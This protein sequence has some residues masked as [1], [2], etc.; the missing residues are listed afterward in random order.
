MRAITGLLARGW[1]ALLLLVVWEL[2]TWA[3]GEAYFPRPS[4]IAAAAY[5]LWFSGPASSLFLTEKALGDFGPSLFNLFTGWFLTAVAGVTLGV[6]LGLSRTVAD[7]V[8]PM[9]HFGRA[10]PPPT[11]LSVFVILFPLGASMQ[12]AV[13]VFG[14]IWPVLI[15]TIDGVRTVER[16]HL[17][18]AE[19][20][21][22]RGPLRLREVVLPAAAP[23]IVA[24]LR[25]SLGLALIL[26]VLSELFGSTTGIGSHLIGMQRSFELP[27]MWA[28]IV[29]L[30]VLGYLLNSVFV[31]IERRWLRWHLTARGAA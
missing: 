24:G 5:E 25:I 13:I 6:A 29:V 12:I 3:V 15:N 18:T 10:I 20:F 1:L 11:L 30:G 16:L 8:E 26:M 9:V 19:V 2:V 4:Q 31:L 27:E 7:Y 21:G 23:K 17:D 14:V 28:G 22:V